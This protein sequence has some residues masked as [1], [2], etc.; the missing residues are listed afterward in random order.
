MDVRVVSFAVFCG[1]LAQPAGALGGHLPI[2]PR[3]PGGVAHDPNTPGGPA[4]SFAPG[5]SALDA[6]VDPKRTGGSARDPNTLGGPAPGS[7]GS[8]PASKPPYKAM[9]RREVTYRVTG[10]ITSASNSRL[11]LS[12]TVRGKKTVDT[13]ILEPGTIKQGNLK[14][15][16]RA[17]VDYRMEKNDKVARRVEVAAAKP[18][19]KSSVKPSGKA[20]TSRP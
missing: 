6:P 19:A 18:A 13:F 3:K 15:G 12:R 10:T 5:A 1:L 16:A 17:T 7:Q 2:N 11:R 14:P 20:S 8:P 4:S 9:S